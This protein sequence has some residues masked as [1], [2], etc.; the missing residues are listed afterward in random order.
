TLNISGGT[1]TFLSPASNRTWKCGMGRRSYWI[2]GSGHVRMAS[3][4]VETDASSLYTRRQAWGYDQKS[5]PHGRG[6]CAGA[7]DGDGVCAVQV[8]TMAG[9]W[10]LRRSGLRP[11]RGIAHEHRPR[12]RRFFEGVHNVRM[13]GKAWLG[14][15]IEVLVS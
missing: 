7:D 10:A 9:F 4:W 15:R 11:H 3:T 6:A 14:A 12:S 1:P 2:P 8:H 13:Q 5:S